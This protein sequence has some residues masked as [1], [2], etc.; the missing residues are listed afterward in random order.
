M[1]EIT[2]NVQILGQMHS[3][4]CRGGNEEDEFAGGSEFTYEWREKQHFCEG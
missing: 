1:L 2:C 4:W 3:G